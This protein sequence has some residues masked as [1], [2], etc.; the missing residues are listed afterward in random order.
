MTRI[1]LARWGNNLALRLPKAMVRE[2]GVT[3]GSEVGIKVARGTLVAKP[4]RPRPNINQLV[5]RITSRNR[6]AATDWG[7][8]VGREVW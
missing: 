6:H 1:A 7:K 2:L 8:P 4:L 5:R 3:E